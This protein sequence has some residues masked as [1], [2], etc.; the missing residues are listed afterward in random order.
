MGLTSLE[1]A[2]EF[3]AV[4]RRNSFAYRRGLAGVPG[5][6]L[7]SCAETEQNNYQ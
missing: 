7:L 5:I 4:N 6:D 1:S 3:I 2:D